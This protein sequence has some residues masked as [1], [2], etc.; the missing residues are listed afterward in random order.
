MLIKFAPLALTPLRRRFVRVGLAWFQSVVCSER[1]LFFRSVEVWSSIYTKYESVPDAE[2]QLLCSRWE[3][4][5]IVQQQFI[6]K[7]FSRQSFWST[8]ASLLL[9]RNLHPQSNYSQE[10]RLGYNLQTLRYNI[11]QHHCRCAHIVGI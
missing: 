10:H 6:F 7:A 9:K 3:H 2:F 5:H 11:S 4:W 8:R 1:L